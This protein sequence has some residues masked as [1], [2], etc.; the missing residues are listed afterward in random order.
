MFSLSSFLLIVNCQLSIVNYQSILSALFITCST[1]S[2]GELF[3]IEL[4]TFC[5]AAFW[6]PNITRAVTASSATAPFPPAAGAPAPAIVS[7]AFTLF[8]KSTRMRCAVFCPIPLPRSVLFHSCW[9]LPGSIRREE[10]KTRS[11]VPY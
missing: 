1:A 6:N 10:E 11:Y 5:E 9:Q 2:I 8:F 3:S 4:T 7:P